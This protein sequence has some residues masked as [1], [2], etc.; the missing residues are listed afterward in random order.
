VLRSLIVLAL[1]GIGA[2]RPPA[3]PQHWPVPRYLEWGNETINAAGLIARIEVKRCGK[4][5]PASE[6]CFK[7]DPYLVAT[8]EAPG[9]EPITIQGEPGVAAFVGI[10]RLIPS[11]AR[12]SLILISKN[13]GSAGCVEIDLAVPQSAGYGRARVSADEYDHGTL[14]QVD[15]SRL[16]WPQDLTGHGHPEFQLWD[17]RFYCRFTSCAGSWY[18]PRV[19]A[20]DGKR[21]IDVSADPALAPLYRADMV[22]ARY[23]CEHARTEAQGACAGYAADAARIGQ[24]P[25]AW[26]VI[27][28][29]VLRGCRVK[30]SDVCYDVNRIPISFPAE[31][32]PLLPGA[33]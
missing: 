26:R 6:A 11:A 2:S 24:L 19:I 23:A 13:G 27:Q 15:P 30:F 18:P 31:L 29:Q 12:A 7:D 5:R 33:G 4:D 25:Q 21:G 8:V 22:R 14:C 1:L 9:M 16:A 28:A 10:G 3:P 17:T 20:L 32:A